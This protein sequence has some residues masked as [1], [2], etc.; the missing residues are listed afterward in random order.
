MIQNLALYLD[1]E[2][3]KIIHVLSVLII[4]YGGCWRFLTGVWHLDHVLDGLR[5]LAWIFPNVLIT[6]GSVKAQIQS[7]WNE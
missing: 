1:L 6:L 5:D 2:G 4:I 7:V 3:A